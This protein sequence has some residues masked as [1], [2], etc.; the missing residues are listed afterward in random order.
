MSYE[1]KLHYLEGYAIV[2]R[3]IAILEMRLHKEP[4]TAQQ[5]TDMPG[6]STTGD[7]VGNLVVGALEATRRLPE[8]Y[9][10]RARILSTIDAME[11][12]LYRQLVT[13]RFIDGLTHEETAEVLHVSYSVVTHG[14]RSAI[15]SIKIPKVDMILQ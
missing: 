11:N 13:C 9:E 4:L 14:Q 6:G 3:D 15:N 2:N 10:R 12:A 7:P 1:D 5:I 8:L